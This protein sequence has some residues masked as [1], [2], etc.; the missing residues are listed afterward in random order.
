MAFGISF[1]TNDH[2]DSIISGTSVPL[3]YWGRKDITHTWTNEVD[4]KN[5]D[6]FNFPSS[7]E[8]V[9]FYVSL[10]DNKPIEAE[11]R[12]VGG[13]WVIHLD[14][15]NNVDPSGTKTFR[16]YAFVNISKVALPT[17]F[18][19]IIYK[20]DGAPAFHSGRP[21]LSIVGISSSTAVIWPFKPASTGEVRRYNSQTIGGNFESNTVYGAF[22]HK[23]FAGDWVADGSINWTSNTSSYYVI[24]SITTKPPV[25]N[26]DYYDLFPSLGN[27]A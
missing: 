6:A 11:P 3:V 14:R 1:G 9:F 20:N 19:L 25:I 5:Y 4:S 12:I 26:G 18:G 8:V 24:P 10:T 23:N 21:P 16:V 27:Y 7:W 13:K 15:S 17:G 2:I 22:A